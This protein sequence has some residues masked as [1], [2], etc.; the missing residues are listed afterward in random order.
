[1]K[2]K[3]YCDLDGVFADFYSGV[4]FLCGKPWHHPSFKSDAERWD[5]LNKIPNFWSR[6][7]KM[8]YAK[9]M[10]DGI[11]EHEPYIL[12]VC[13][14]EMPQGENQKKDWCFEQLSIPRERVIVVFSRH[15]KQ[16]YAYDH[17]TETPNVLIDD[18][19]PNIVQ[20]RQAG[21]IGILHLSVLE[22]LEALKEVRL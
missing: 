11:A 9:Y 12:T 21:G 10:A 4:Q 14:P 13:P 19:L 3:L 5:L 8:A 1:M 20:W 2:G 6:L 17:A 15:D 22:T 16:E 18:Y 7:P